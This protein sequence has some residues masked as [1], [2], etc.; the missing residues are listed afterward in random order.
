MRALI[1]SPRFPWPP[2]TGDR[3]RATIWLAALSPHAHVTLVAPSGGVP[4][5]APRF[6]FH[7]ASRSWTHALLGAWTAIRDRLPLQCLMA[8]RFDWRNAVKRATEEQGP[9]DVTVVILSRMHPWVHRTLQGRTVLDAVD[10]LRRSAEQRALEAAPLMRWLWRSEE[11]RMARLESD[12]ARLY[13]RVLVVNE[14]EKAEFGSAE[15]VPNG[16]EILPEHEGSRA[17]DFG[18]W[19]RFP[20]FANRDAAMWLLDEIWPAIRALRPSATLIVGGAEASA[21]LRELAGKRGVVMVSPIESVAAFAR[22]IRVA[23]MPVRFGTGQL[24]KV[25]EAAEAGCAIVGT[26]QALRGLPTLA[27]HARM[28]STAAGIARA[29]VEVIDDP[30]PPGKRVRD[31]VVAS[32]ARST[33]TARLSSIAAGADA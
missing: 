6:H 23:L 31:A 16:V 30:K 21:S 7:P 3:L 14:D 1:I 19:G 9:F 29:A 13:D 10:S 5:H 33:T 28:E 27:V 22:N 2:Y 32:Y 24:G 15:A 18:F 11:R 17:F 25:L 26:P 12:A 8:A 4:Q 20:Y